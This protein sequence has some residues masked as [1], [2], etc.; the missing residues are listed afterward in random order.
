MKSSGTILGIV[1]FSI[2]VLGLQ[3]IPQ[4]S[5]AQG[6]LG[7]IRDTL[8]FDAANGVTPQIIQVNGDVFSLQRRGFRFFR[9][10]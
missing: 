7:S 1:L 6:D 2:L 10:I 9:Q 4:A 5:A 3:N 8:E